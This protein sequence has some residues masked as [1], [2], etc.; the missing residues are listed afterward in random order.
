MLI[1]L[2]HLTKTLQ[3]LATYWK[4][5]KLPQIV[6]K[7]YIKQLSILNKEEFDKAIELWIFTGK[8]FP[9]P[10]E[11]LGKAGRSPKQDAEVQWL[12]ICQQ[13]PRNTIAQQCSELLKPLAQLRGLESLP[14]KEYSYKEQ[15]IK[16]AFIEKYTE[17]YLLRLSEGSLA[18]ALLEVDP[19]RTQPKREENFEPITPEQ[20]ADLRKRING[21]AN[22]N[23]GKRLIGEDD[24]IEF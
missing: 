22:K 16:T 20:M 10:E 24:D 17:A 15:Q 12:K 1:S 13:Q 21:I 4:K 7:S 3:E 6:L 23:I 19:L 11:L 9:T 2:D 18:E 5:G 8:S 14:A